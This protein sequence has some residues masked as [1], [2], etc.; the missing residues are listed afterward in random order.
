MGAFLVYMRFIDVG[1]TSISLE[2]GKM[3]SK[4]ICK[5]K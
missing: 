4:Y 1:C 3:M 5:V 2:T